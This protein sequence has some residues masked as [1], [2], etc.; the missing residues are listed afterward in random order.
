MKL[1]IYDSVCHIDDNKLMV[2]PQGMDKNTF[3][4]RLASENIIPSGKFTKSGREYCNFA[5]M[6]LEGDLK[7]TTL[8]D[9]TASPL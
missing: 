2:I 6:I 8:A 1:A 5:P 4:K 7:F 9:I 3:A